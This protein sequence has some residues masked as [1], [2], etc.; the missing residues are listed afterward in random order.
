MPILDKKN[1]QDTARYTDFVRTSPYGNALQDLAWT[2]VKRNW[3]S[4]QVYLEQDGKI[5]AAMSILF[6][7]VVG[8]NTLAY[9]SRGPVCDPYDLE[10]VNRLIEE[11]KPVLKAH[12]AIFLRMDPEVNYDEK[13]DQLYRN[14][15]FR[16]RNQGFGKAE[17]IQ[18]RYNMILPLRGKTFDEL[19][20]GFSSK[21][22]YNIRLSQRK[23]V[24]TAYYHDDDA[25]KT[26]YEIYRI[27]TE[28]DGIGHRPYWYFEEM[29]H[30]YDENH[31]RI[32]I[33]SHEG[34]PLSAAIAIN[35]GKKMWYLYGASSNEKRN[36][37]PNYSMQRAMIE[38][39]IE[40]GCQLYDFGGV[41]QLDSS[42]GLYHFKE[43]FCR[44]NGVTEFIGEF[45]QVY[46]PMGYFLFTK[47]IP[48]VQKLKKKLRSRKK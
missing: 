23:G 44:E 47:G 40:C 1:A 32:Y 14:A 33:S 11:A 13:L 16:V 42:D 29:I 6:Q 30:A 18:P 27:T 15:G 43:G 34:Q 45:D 7:K 3:D 46:Q 20:P 31:L 28:R 39:G 25:L 24:T 19:M 38:W 26:F 41:Y 37:M 48:A 35:Y 36:L 9:A 5:I 10:L 8:K 21:T 22:R 12:H 17:L 4:E 2:K